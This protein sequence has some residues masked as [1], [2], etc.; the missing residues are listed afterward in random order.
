MCFAELT[1]PAQKQKHNIPDKKKNQ[2]NRE[3]V[4]GAYASEL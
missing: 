2:S 3:K 4:S 1:I